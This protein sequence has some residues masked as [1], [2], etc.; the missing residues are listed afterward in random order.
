MTEVGNVGDE[1]Q[2]LLQAEP[3]STEICL[4]IRG[5]T[6]EHWKLNLVFQAAEKLVHEGGKWEKSS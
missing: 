2:E 6:I 1:E 3:K 4:V 5:T